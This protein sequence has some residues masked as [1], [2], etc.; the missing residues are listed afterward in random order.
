MTSMESAALIAMD[1]AY[2]AMED[3]EASLASAMESIAKATVGI[4]ARVGVCKSSLL[5][6]EALAVAEREV[7]NAIGITGN[8]GRPIVKVESE[9]KL[10]EIANVIRQRPK[11]EGNTL[12]VVSG[13]A[14]YM[15]TRK[16]SK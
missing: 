2:K 10:R 1:E 4:A 8:Y 14:I 3:W 6:Y 16:Q 9:E 7:A 15:H 11:V 12:T 5:A 13:E